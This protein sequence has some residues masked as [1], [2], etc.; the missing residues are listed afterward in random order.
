MFSV[1][2]EIKFP[3][4][5]N[6]GYPK[7]IMAFKA[8]MLFYEIRLKFCVF[9]FFQFTFCMFV[10]HQTLDNMSARIFKIVWRFY[11]RGKRDMH[12]TKPTYASGK[13]A[14]TK[15]ASMI[16]GLYLFGW[17]SLIKILCCIVNGFFWTAWTKAVSLYKG[18]KYKCIFKLI[19]IRNC[20]VLA[21]H[22]S[23][24]MTY[25]SCWFYR[26]N[27]GFGIKP[28]HTCTHTFA[29]SC[30]YRVFDVLSQAIHTI[31]P[32]LSII[33]TLWIMSVYEKLTTCHELIITMFSLNT[34]WHPS[35]YVTH[36][37]LCILTLLNSSVVP[38]KGPIGSGFSKYF[39]HLLVNQL[40][41]W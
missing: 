25:F 27:T 31:L 18:R 34:H 7:L 40:L 12:E 17:S 14:K 36:R 5:P 39:T 37:Y 26:L 3:E 4:Y 29:Y 9:V 21:I 1:R 13:K 24:L 19:C 35:M 15:R 28:K 38:V 33:S 23:W 22:C 10:G 2:C 41:N 16:F 8:F 20:D 6:I 30:R 32:A 11:W